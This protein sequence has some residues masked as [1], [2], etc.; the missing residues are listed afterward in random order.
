MFSECRGQHKP[1]GISHNIFGERV[2]FDVNDADVDL[3]FCSLQR[4]TT[5][6]FYEHYYIYAIE[7]STFVTAMLRTVSAN[8]LARYNQLSITIRNVTAIQ[9]ISTN[10]GLPPK[11]LITNICATYG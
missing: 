8:M 7:G 1:A 3:Q 6:N 9:C 2:E 11:L 10:R 5:L 4:P